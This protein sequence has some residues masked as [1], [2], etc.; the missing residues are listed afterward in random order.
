MQKCFTTLGISADADQDAARDA[1]L[2]LV[3]LFHPDSGHKEA[4]AERFSEI[5]NAF[6]TLQAKFAKERRGI[7]DESVVEAQDF[8][9]KV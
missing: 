7:E 1:Y 4:S 9:I 3:K 8:D 2:K 6:R 5:D